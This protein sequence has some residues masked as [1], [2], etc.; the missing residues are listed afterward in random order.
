MPQIDVAPLHDEFWKALEKNPVVMLG[1][2]TSSKHHI[3]MRAQLDKNGDGQIWFF[4]GRNHAISTGGPANAQFTAASH[5]FYA[6]LRGTLVEETDTD[7]IDKHWSNPVA[8]WYEK[9]REDP[10]LIMLRLDI[11]T[12]EFWTADMTLKGM[13]HML[14]GTPI[15]SKDVGEHAQ[16]SM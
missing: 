14:T 15:Q 6:S 5:N 1:L 16:V 3:P 2:D 9:G 11:A 12:A 8:A 4:T 7:V 13:F 10:N